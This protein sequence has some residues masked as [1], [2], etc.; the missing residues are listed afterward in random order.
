MNEYKKSIFWRRIIAFII[1]IAILFPIGFLIA[2][3]IDFI[4]SG[5]PVTP[6]EV[7]IRTVIS[8]SIPFWMYSILSDYS[9]SGSS[10]GK[11]IM[12]IQVVSSE[13]G[14]LKL[15]QAISRT[16]VKLIPW[17]MVHISFFALS[18]GWGIFSITQIIL[19]II[20]NVLILIYIIFVIKMKG[21][22]AIH[23]LIPKT[24]VKLKN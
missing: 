1:D 15:H 4:T 18:E 3:L 19:I 5:A 14:K 8:F 6:F 9:K 10:L 11:K 20:L 7:Y 12:K 13:Q 24:Q 2:F 17:E 22:K 23:D 21:F 16:A